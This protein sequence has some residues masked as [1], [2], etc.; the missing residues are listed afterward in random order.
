LT[1]VH[2]ICAITDTQLLPILAI[3]NLIFAGEAP[4]IIKLGTIVPL[5]KDLKRARP[6]KYLD[7]IF[8]IVDKAV[9]TR[10]ML[11]CQECGLLPANSFGFIPGGS[12]E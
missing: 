1:T 7:V 3:T 8:K 5:P 6:I 12:Y 2:E 11:V 9:G 10:L 4:E